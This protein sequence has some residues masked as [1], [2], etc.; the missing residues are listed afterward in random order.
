MDKIDHNIYTGI[1]VLQSA[2]DSLALRNAIN[3]C[4]L[5]KSFE[6]II[7]DRLFSEH[8]LE[9]LRSNH[10]RVCI[11]TSSIACYETLSLLV[12]LPYKSSI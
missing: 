10:L 6:C 9:N 4:I 5:I 3:Q 2:G 1:V 12:S 11:M 7:Y 8:F